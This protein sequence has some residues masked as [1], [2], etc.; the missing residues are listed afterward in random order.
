MSPARWR[1]S[2]EARLRDPEHVG[3]GWHEYTVNEIE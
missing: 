2:D 1:A 3:H